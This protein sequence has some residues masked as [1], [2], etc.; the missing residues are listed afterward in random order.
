MSRWTGTHTLVRVRI[1]VNFGGYLCGKSSEVHVLSVLRKHKWL[2]SV[3]A[4]MLIASTSCGSGTETAES[5]P[6]ATTEPPDDEQV[7]LELW[8][9]AVEIFISQ[10]WARIPEDC[11]PEFR[12]GD[13]RSPAE[14]QAGWRADAARL[15][16]MLEQMSYGEPEITVAGTSGIIKFKTFQDG[17]EIPWVDVLL[18]TKSEDG[19][20]YRN[21]P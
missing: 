9:K 6:S 11:T 3:V 14:I 18:Y 17:E 4:V 19:T 5:T 8:D 12:E 15:G 1:T 7:L 16:Y 10:Q 2:M 13:T 20:W 21:C